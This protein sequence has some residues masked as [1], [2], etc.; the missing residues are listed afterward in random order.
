[1][2]QKHP[3]ANTTACW[4]GADASAASFVGGGTGTDFPPP[5]MTSAGETAN[6]ASIPRTTIPV[7]AVRKDVFSM[8]PPSLGTVQKL[9]TDWSSQILESFAQIELG[10]KVFYF[11][12]VMAL[13]LSGLDFN[14]WS[15]PI[16]VF[17]RK[18]RPQEP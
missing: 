3:P 4:P 2:P 9:P 12:A 18:K 13:G 8:T 5:A 11:I 17:S 6:Q 15:A 14:T 16:S 7:N 1:M 10:G